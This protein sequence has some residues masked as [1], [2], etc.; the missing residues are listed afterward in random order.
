MRKPIPRVIPVLLLHDG[1]LYKSV[2][3]KKHQYVGDPINAVRI[4]ND[5]EADELI[6]LDIDASAQRRAPDWSLLE[7]LAGEAFM[8]VC[9]GGGLRNLD[10]FDRAFAAGI[11]KVSVNAAVL[12]DPSLLE[13]AANRFGSQSVAAVIDAKRALRGWRVLGEN[14][15]RKTGHDPVTLAQAYA[16]SGA[17]EIV[18]QSVDRDGR[19]DGYDLEL[20]RA[21]ADAVAVPVVALGGARGVD[22]F[23]QAF[24]AGA[25]AA[26]AGSA[27]VFHGE[28]RAVLI[29]YLT[30]AERSSVT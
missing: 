26:A 27:F 16:A 22:D 24:A 1:G 8:P 9:Y 12:A 7:E 30:E 3:F 29:S 20:I 4:F 10:D 25:S 15:R 21:V 14:G 5:K 18:I 17:G 23:R 19:R 13:R 6:V 28:R 2:E 11:E